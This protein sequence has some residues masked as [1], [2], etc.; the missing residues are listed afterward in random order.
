MLAVGTDAEGHGSDAD[1]E[2]AHDCGVGLP[3]G[4]LCVPTTSGGP[5]FLGVPASGI[6]EHGEFSLEVYQ[7]YGIFP[8]P[9][10]LTEMQ[11]KVFRETKRRL[12]LDSSRKR[13]EAEVAVNRRS[14]AKPL[15]TKMD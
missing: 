2:S 6:R 5:D 3:V 13:A 10:I 11:L 8:P 9:P 12:R 14:N 15:I 7:T 4:R 1:H